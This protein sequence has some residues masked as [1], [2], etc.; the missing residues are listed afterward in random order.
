MAY[1]ISNDFVPN[2]VRGLIDQ[3]AYAKDEYKDTLTM[4]LLVSYVREAFTAL[5]EL[6]ATAEVPESGKTTI[7]CNIPLL[8]AFNAWKITRL[9]TID[10]MRAKYLERVKP[11]P[12]ADDIGKVFGDNGTS[13]KLSW[14][15]A[16][17]I[18]CY[19][20]EGKVEVSRS[21]VNQSLSSYGMAF[22]NG[23]KNAVP[24]DLFT[25]A[26][27]FEGMEPAPEGLELRDAMSSD[28]RAD[29]K[30]LR[31][32]M[33]SWAGS[34]AK[35]MTAYMNGPVKY[36]HPALISRKRQ[37]WGPL[38]AAA[39]EAGGDWPRRIYEAFVSIELKAA[40]RPSL[41]AE[42]KLLLDTA[43]IIMRNGGDRFFA[44]ELLA[45]LRARP[46][47]DYYRKADDKSLLKD[48]FAEVFGP[49]ERIAVR[50][51]GR[52]LGYRA[53]PILEAAA[54]LREAIYPRMTP[55]E[56]ELESE[57]AITPLTPVVPL[58]TAA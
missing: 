33:A 49:P 44:T 51:V 38:F 52:G 41:V 1:G 48:K 20:E 35:S 16:L 8:L 19:T 17:L 30:L 58:R 25:R 53:A 23:L 57:F 34:R 7:A 3:L 11:N 45:M 18:D 32:A 24:P 26:I 12:V 22:M 39:N 43:D 5:P 9:T 29:A 55:A 4:M 46:E 56:D 6:L 40:E 10:A 36:V 21:G 27:H 37:K 47:G 15:Y 50:G 31:A 2:K 42:Q 28:V 14:M 54:D 13:G